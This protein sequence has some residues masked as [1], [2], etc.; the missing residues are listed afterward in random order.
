MNNGGREAFMDFLLK[1]DI[2]KFDPYL[3]LHT[4][5]VDEQK[6]RSLSPVAEYWLRLLDDGFLPYDDVRDVIGYDGIRHIVIV[7]KLVW[8]FNEWNKRYHNGLPLTTKAFGKL[9]R[10]IVPDMPEAHNVKCEARDI[11]DNRTIDR[12]FNSFALPEIGV[13]REFFVKHNSWLGRNWVNAEKWER[14]HIENRWY[15]GM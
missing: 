5:E 13:C 2:S 15:D 7:D 14:L 11:I 3:P 1:R 8:C 6:E 9:F 12:R 10:K 4:L